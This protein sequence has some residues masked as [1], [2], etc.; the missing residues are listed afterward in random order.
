MQLPAQG[1]HAANSLPL[2][3][4]P[5]Q[6]KKD[7][8]RGDCTAVGGDY[9]RSE[10]SFSYN[11]CNGVFHRCGGCI[12]VKDKKKERSLLRTFPEFHCYFRLFSREITS[13]AGHG[14]TEPDGIRCFVLIQEPACAGAHVVGGIFPGAAFVY[15]CTV[16]DE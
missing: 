4:S 12:V 13:D 14:A 7:A 3:L 10:V 11:R 8:S 6:C 16:G 1:L 5:F 9:S 2:K 15:P